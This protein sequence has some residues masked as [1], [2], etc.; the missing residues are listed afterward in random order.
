MAQI[1]LEY[2]AR[3]PIARKTIEYILSLG[4]FKKKTRIDEA[5]ED[6]KKGKVYKAENAKDLL[7]KC[8]K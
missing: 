8:L 1:T 3:N 4:V 2:D 7:Y 6:V 5:L